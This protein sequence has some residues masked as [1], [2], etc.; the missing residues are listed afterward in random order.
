MVSL[1]TWSDEL[2]V[3]VSAFDNQHKRLVALIN[4]LHDAMSA[5]KGSKVLGKILSE[6]ADYTVYHFKAEEAVFET[7][8]YPGLGSH[9]DSHGELT[10]QVLDFKD[11]FEAGK[12]V[13]SME[14][15]KFLTD[16]LT[17]HILDTDKAYTAFLNSRGVS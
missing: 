6:L 7:Y 3:G 5:G 13:L 17:N 4:E 9:R 10:R 8:G 16:W 1:I 12:A 15:M 2:S 14:L 11:Q